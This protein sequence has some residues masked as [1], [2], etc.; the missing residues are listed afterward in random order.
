[1]NPY[2]AEFLGTMLL[3]ILGDGVVANVLL[4]RSKGQNGGWIV[5]ATGWGLAVMVGAY[6]VGTISGAH[7]NP[8]VTLALAAIGQ[9]K[10]AFVPGYIAAQIAGAF[11]GAVLVWLAYLPHWSITEDKGAKLAV[12][13]TGPAV[14]KPALNVLTEAIGTFMLVVGVLAIPSVKN[15]D[16]KL[17]FATGLGPLLVGLLV[18]SIGL[19]LGGPTGYAIN[20]ARDFGPRLAHFILPISGKGSSDWG[21]AL[22]PIVG[23]IVGGVAGAVIYKALWGIAGPIG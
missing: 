15:L 7:M 23:P 3:I 21:Y 8:A 9:F 12:F 17:G 18:F 6:A 5:I 2:V 20:P 16:P 14:R 1:M 4:N 22:V 11:A 19:S 13:C 10:V